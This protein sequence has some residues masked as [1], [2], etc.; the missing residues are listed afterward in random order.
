MVYGAVVIFWVFT[1]IF[2]MYVF[3]C[4][5]LQYLLAILAFTI[6]HGSEVLLGGF[7]HIAIQ[8]AKRFSQCAAR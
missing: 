3:L 1:T 6:F 7:E 4:Y 2:L 8:A 5:H